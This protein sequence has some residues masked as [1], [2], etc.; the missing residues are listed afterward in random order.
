MQNSTANTA[1]PDCICHSKHGECPARLKNNT[2]SRIR[3][4][5]I[6]V[7]DRLRPRDG[8]VDSFINRARD[9]PRLDNRASI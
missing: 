6:A 2:L 8:A 3:L 1:K 7:G 4:Q 9:L 5:V